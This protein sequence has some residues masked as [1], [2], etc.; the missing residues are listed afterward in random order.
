MIF[1]MR[2]RYNH[3]V[4][5]QGQT[6]PEG[7]VQE[8]AFGGLPEQERTGN[9]KRGALHR[10]EH[11][12][13]EGH[14]WP[15]IRP[16]IC[17]AVMVIM[18]VQIVFG[19]VWMIRN[20]DTVP[21]FGDT[22]EYL[23]L[24]ESLVL[25]EYRP[26][27]YP[28][29]LR[30]ARMLDGE[31]YHR[32]I[33]ILQTGLCL[34]A[35][36]YAVSVF[37]TVKNAGQKR[38]LGRDWKDTARWIYCGLFLTTIPMIT[39]MNFTVLTDSFANSLLVLFLAVSVQILY[40]KGISTGRCAGLGVCLTLQ[41]ILRADRLYSGLLL[42]VIL[43]VIAVVRA[44]AGRKMIA[45]SMAC[46]AAVS[47]AAVKVISSATQTPGIN[48][49]VQTNL[50]FVL[51]DRVVWP[52]MAENYE[53]FPQ[54]IRDNISPEEAQ[55]FDSHNNKV[56]YQLAPTLESRVGKEKAEAYYRTMA[57]IVWEKNHGAILTDIGD[58]FVMTMVT[59]L[60]HYLAIRGIYG[61]TNT[62]WNTHCLSQTTPELTA[63][64]DRW[65]FYILAILLAI[66]LLVKIADVTAE[67]AGRKQNGGQREKGGWVLLPFILAGAIICL[68]FALGD[69]AAPNDRY[70]LI[71]FTTYG[72]MAAW[73]AA[74]SLQGQEEE[75]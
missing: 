43:G 13:A 37:D 15:R 73:P 14:G 51:L 46:V 2:K 19:M 35:M 25:D 8:P 38:G 32:Y 53:A 42:L 55:E 68:W 60:M 48:G 72:I 59:P 28:L 66:S 56:M 27:L 64:Y 26:V 16:W 12:R 71:V 29:I 47:F 34:F 40:G 5:A 62:G 11:A 3:S 22:G 9:V 7:P 10:A 41:S 21:C 6:G 18:L 57:K 49:R 4:C 54:E 31:H 24:S 1:F 74:V 67:R 65:G 36:A 45:L 44:K 52:H 70:T 69:G 75:R 58:S 50:S 23:R 61:K 30:G 20:F 63:D 33:Y 39:F 17:R